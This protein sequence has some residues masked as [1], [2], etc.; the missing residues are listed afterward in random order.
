[1]RLNDWKAGAMR[2]EDID[3]D[4]L[5]KIGREQ[6]AQ[7]EQ[8]V[9]IDNGPSSVGALALCG[10]NVPIHHVT[11]DLDLVTCPKCQHIRTDATEREQ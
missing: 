9:H 2:F 4:V 11:R 8:A 7:R 10:G 5:A 1:M 3:R 6:D